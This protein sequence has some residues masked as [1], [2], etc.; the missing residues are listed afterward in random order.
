MDIFSNLKTMSR[1]FLLFTNL[2][3]TEVDV[4]SYFHSILKEQNL[5]TEDLKEKLKPLLPSLETNNS[6]V[7][8]LEEDN[9]YPSPFV[10]L[11]QESESLILIAEDLGSPHRVNSSQ[12][13]RMKALLD[14]SSDPIFGFKEDGTYFYVNNVFGQTLGYKKEEIINKKIWDIFPQKEADKRFAVVQEVFN[15]GTIKTIEVKIPLPDG[16][17]YFLTTAKPFNKEGDD[18]VEF[19]ICISKDI[20]EL[21]NT[22]E[23]LKT[24]KGLIPICS[25]CKNI[26]NDE[27]SWQQ[28]EEYISKNSEAQFS[29]GICPECVQTLYPGITLNK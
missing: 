14:E 8:P 5:S 27:G 26:K 29:H 18:G 11:H 2:D 20:T 13:T 10:V 12:D 21:R 3:G 7:L 1:D 19:V 6:I 16:D 23:Q 28:L 4:G 25:N 17:K 9:I 22:Q 15:T 24:L